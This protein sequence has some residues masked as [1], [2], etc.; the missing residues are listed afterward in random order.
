MCQHPLL[1]AM[2]LAKPRSQLQ[3]FDYLVA[4]PPFSVKS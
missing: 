3:T 2:P 1:K 4:N